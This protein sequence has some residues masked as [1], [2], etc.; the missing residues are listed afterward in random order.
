M[1]VKILAMQD[2][3]RAYPKYLDTL[4]PYHTSFK[5]PMTVHINCWMGGE[6]FRS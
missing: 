1:V 4:T 2:N 6:Q 5:N 3:Y